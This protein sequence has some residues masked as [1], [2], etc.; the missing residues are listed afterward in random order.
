MPDV[1]EQQRE[2][3]STFMDAIGKLERSIAADPTGQLV[4][5][6]SDA[7]QVGLDD[8][9]FVQLRDSLDETNRTV[10]SGEIALAQISL[11]TPEDAHA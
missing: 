8:D 3:A 4:L 10:S 1:V 6:I 11:Q 9:V 2:L 5:G 7:S